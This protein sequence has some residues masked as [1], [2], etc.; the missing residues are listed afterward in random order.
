MFDVLK[1]IF[2]LSQDGWL[3]FLL[4]STVLAILGIN[5]VLFKRQRR[6]LA[7]TR[8]ILDKTS[9]FARLTEDFQ[10]FSTQ[11]DDCFADMHTL[12]DKSDSKM[13]A[14]HQQRHEQLTRYHERVAQV[15]GELGKDLAEL[16]GI[17]SS[18]VSVTRI[19][20]K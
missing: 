7:K 10:I 16:K 20:I 1:T 11:I 3:G 17:L 18:G 19:G 5:V 6:L 2:D 4:L 14:N 8:K 12:I 13:D 15:S 9:E